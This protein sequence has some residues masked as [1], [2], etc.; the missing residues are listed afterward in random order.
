MKRRG[1]RP[2][3]G[4]RFGRWTV[5]SEA[6]NRGRRYRSLCLCDC[7][8][9]RLVENRYLAN[10]QSISCGCARSDSFIERN[11]TH[12]LTSHPLFKVWDAMVY[13]CHT[14]GSHSYHNYGGRGIAVCDRWRFGDD[15]LSG[16]ECFIKDMG[17]KPTHEHSLDRRD[18]DGPYSP[19]NCRW[20]TKKEQ[21]NNRRLPRRGRAYEEAHPC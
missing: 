4:E 19:D 18:N 8:H 14:P 5:L 1:Y 16:P 7:G 20:A 11:T 13:R 17:P 12:G 2:T 3:P 15:G 6:A 21:A 9:E 10:G